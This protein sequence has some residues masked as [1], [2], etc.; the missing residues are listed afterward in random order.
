MRNQRLRFRWWPVLLA[1]CFFQSPAVLELRAATTNLHS[2]WKV[3]GTS[4]VVYLLGS[5]HLLKDSD[6]PLPAPIESA[7]SNAS[8][9]VFETDVGAMQ[10]PATQFQMLSKVTLPLGE[11]LESQLSPEVYSNFTRHATDAGLPML[12]F[13]QL[14]PAMAAMTLE[15]FELTKLGLDPEHGLDEHFF[16][17]AKEAG[18]QI[19]PLETVEF[20]LGLVTDFT[21]DEGELMMK[22]TLEEIDNTKKLYDK[23]VKAWKTGDAAGLAQLLNDDV[24]KAPA[25]YK[26]LLTDRNKNWMPKIEKLLHGDKNAIVIVGAGHLVGADGV[27]ELLKKDGF[28]VTQL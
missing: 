19:I 6:Y 13:N 20:Q 25:I 10:E 12:I 7:F 21:K 3:Q 26:R 14:K 9:A 28:K 2:L 4:N 11:T 18:K 27:V 23:M 24:R 17:L 22:T 8:I 15:V 1:L 5:V 16:N